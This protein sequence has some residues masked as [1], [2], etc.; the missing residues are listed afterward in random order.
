M[1]IKKHTVFCFMEVTFV[2]AHYRIYKD[3]EL[4]NEGNLV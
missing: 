1:L 2:T 3:L 4:S